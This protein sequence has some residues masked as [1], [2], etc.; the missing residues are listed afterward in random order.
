MRFFFGLFVFFAHA[1]LHGM[2]SDNKS[3]LEMTVRQNETQGSELIFCFVIP[4]ACSDAEK[5]VSV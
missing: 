3:V 2:F 5:V 4:K 1:A